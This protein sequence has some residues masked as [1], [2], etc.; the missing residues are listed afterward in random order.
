MQRLLISKD[1]IMTEDITPIKERIKYL[2]N[3]MEYQ[4]ENKL[5]EWVSTNK[6]IRGLRRSMYEEKR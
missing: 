4:I 6:K 3:K 5:P 1:D 2:E